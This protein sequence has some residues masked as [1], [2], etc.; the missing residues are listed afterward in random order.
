MTRSKAVSVQ[1]Y[2]TDLILT[3][4]GN[5]Q[6]RLTI[7]RQF[8]GSEYGVQQIVFADGTVWDEAAL[9]EMVL[10][11]KPDND[12]LVGSDGDNVLSGFGGHDTLIG[13]AGDDVLDGGEG[14]DS[15]TGGAGNDLLIGGLGSDTYR[16]GYGF[17]LDTINNY[18]DPGVESEG[19][20]DSIQML[21]NI[22]SS[23]VSLLRYGD[24]LVLL[25]KGSAG[26]RLTVSGYFLGEAYRI[27]HIYLA[28]TVW[29][30][31]D[32]QKQVTRTSTGTDY[33]LGTDGDDVL[34]GGSGNDWIDGG[35]GSDTVSYESAL[36]AVNV[37]LRWN[38]RNVGGGEGRDSFISIENLLG[39]AFNDRLSGD[40]N[41][42]VL[43]GGSGND[44]LRGQG[45]D[46][47]L[48]GGEGDDNLVSGDGTDDLQGGAGNDV[49]SGFGGNDTLSGGDGDDY[50][51]GGQ[52]NDTMFGGGNNDTIDGGDGND[53]IVGEAAQLPGIL[54]FGL[55]TSSRWLRQGRVR[56]ESFWRFGR[57][58]SQPCRTP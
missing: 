19:K 56:T 22:R 52:G 8:L 12:Y 49:L 43:T 41:S 33:H 32:V 35:N 45:G 53:W 39:T 11:G 31:A 58:G 2:D 29:Y 54:G 26:G 50:L 25:L 7:S 44:V 48:I 18:A 4:D 51:Y 9:L 14:D 20:V 37:D 16:F 28:D 46:D 17:G 21:D 13:D 36:G 42:N 6:D 34:Q 15:L 5:T 40:A 47:T 38:G 55:I 30:E 57:R 10:Q 1:R 3:F 23:D 24:D 27:Q